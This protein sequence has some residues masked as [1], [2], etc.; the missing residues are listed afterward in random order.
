MPKTASA[1]ARSSICEPLE[2]VVYA[3][4]SKCCVNSGRFLTSPEGPLHHPCVLVVEDEV[5]SRRALAWL[6]SASG[7]ETA[8]YESAEDA[9]SAIDRDHPDIALVDVDLP[10]MS[11][12]ELASELRRNNPNV[13][14]VLLTAA[15]GERITSFRARHDVGYVRK[16]VDFPH[17]LRLLAAA[18]PPN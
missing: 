11:G 6:L 2:G 8:A 4:L 18:E 7:F 15:E 17:L 16:P 1:T 9:L 13:R 10:G 12:L 3:L 14:I 5:I